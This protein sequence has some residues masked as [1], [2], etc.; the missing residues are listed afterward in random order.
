MIG[1]TNSHYKIL[2]KLGKSGM[3]V[4]Y[5]AED[6]DLKRTVALK[7]LSPQALGSEEEEGR[8]IYE[9]QSAAALDHSSI[10]T[11]YEI[12]KAEEHAFIAMA[13]IEGQSLN[14]RIESGPLKLD[15]AV[16]IAIQVAEGLQDAHENGRADGA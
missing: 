6:T 8:F 5:K 7:F 13:F 2:E 9:T 14:G 15:E 4:V 12:S 16:D 11:I 10:C 1:K 3:G